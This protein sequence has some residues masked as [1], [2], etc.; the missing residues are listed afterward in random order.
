MITLFLLF[1]LCNSSFALED[2]DIEE[3]VPIQIESRLKTNSS[4]FAQKAVLSI[5]KYDLRDDI[6]VNVRN[7]LSTNNCW[8]FS[9]LSV[10]ETNIEKSSKQHFWYSGRHMNYATSKSFLNGINLSAHNREVND[11]GNIFVGLAY[12]TSG[13]GPVLENDMPF[14]ENESL[15][16]SQELEGKT[17]NKMIKNYRIF[18]SIVKRKQA[19]GNMRY[20]DESG[21]VEY[22]EN[23]VA[24][25]R[26][27]I[28]EHIIN[29]GS[30]AT[31]TNTSCIYSGSQV[32]SAYCDDE[33]RGADHQVT[34]IGWDDNYAIENF[35]SSCRPSK[36]GA[37]IALNSWG[38]QYGDRG[39]FYISYED[40]FVENG[41]VGIVETS[42]ID[43]EKIYQYDP[44]GWSTNMIINGRNTLYGA[45]VFQ[46]NSNE[47]EV[48]TEVSIAV[49][50]A[51][52]CEI[53]VNPNDGELTT[54]K[55]IKVSDGII[56]LNAGYNTIELSRP[57]QVNGAN[58]AIVVKY[59]NENAN[60]YIGIEA[61]CNSIYF[62]TAT[63]NK[64]ESFV[65]SNMKD[66]IDLAETSIKN[67]NICIKAFTKRID[68][69][70]ITNSYIIDENNFVTNISPKTLVSEFITKLSK[71]IGKKVLVFD[72]E[73]NEIEKDIYVSTGMKIL[74]NDEDICSAVVK[75]DLNGDGKVSLADVSLMKMHMIRLSL[76]TNEYL[77]ASDINLN[78][79]EADIVDFSTILDVY[80]GTENI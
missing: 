36:P 41:L 15:I 14:S 54:E 55:L 44:L 52:K 61:P 72:K 78:G 33:G 17:I 76:L 43:Y 59:I 49:G 58:F 24:D 22:T 37:Y 23:Q 11:G 69:D 25:I 40:V 51:Q 57:I 79:K 46:C 50:V 66:W 13:R 18:P 75:G 38:S 3:N 12:I 60:A 8:T 73:G 30:I 2:I 68:N 39:C 26:R 9:T 80:F 35:N 65:S 29:Y 5:T 70:K 56:E 27:S 4:L 1:T 21:S 28:K 10:L 42:D 31:S 71:Q 19:D 62:E 47:K 32:P 64:G 53:Y 77:K 48:L 20:F 16:S 7:Q 45:N 6:S 63:S 67:A 74:I 34:I